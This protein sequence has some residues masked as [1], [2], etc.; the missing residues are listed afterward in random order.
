[1]ENLQEYLSTGVQNIAKKLTR[2]GI[3]SLKESAFTA[4]FLISCKAAGV[5]RERFSESGQHIPP[6]LIASITK[7]CNLF[8]KGCYSREL[9]KDAACVAE[10]SSE[11][12]SAVFSEA[13]DIGVSFILLAG[14]EPLM[15]RDVI[16]AA[17]KHKNILFPIFTNGTMFDE[18]YLKLFDKNRNLLPVLSI[19]GERMQTDERRGENIY[20]TILSEMEKLQRKQILFGASI[21][22]T[23]ENLKLVTDK[24]YIQ[25]LSDKGCALVFFIEYVPVTKNEEYLAFSDDERLPFESALADLRTAFSNMLL[26]SFPGDE[27]ALGGCLAAGRGFFHISA[28]GNAEPCP[29]S[30]YSDLNLKD[31]TLL[32][33]LNSPLFEALKNT[34][35]LEEEHSG[36]CTLF[37]RRSEVK[38]LILQQSDKGD[39]YEYCS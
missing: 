32:E 4:N 29:F 16:G 18:K 37:A 17:A 9:N 10:L 36:G 2:L 30:P 38:E 24:E 23:T 20:N 1:M 39:N 12:W 8:C 28:S 14:G 22:V 19:E 34:G 35:I 6:F 33:A 25:F 13:E 5:K 15:R 31:C 3:G 26:I 11:K 21:T 7:S 27:K